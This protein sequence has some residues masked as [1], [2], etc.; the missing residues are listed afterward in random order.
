M[1]TH[2]DGAADTA[3]A[4]ADHIDF[5]NRHASEFAPSPSEVDGRLALIKEKHARMQ[6]TGDWHANLHDFPKDPGMFARRAPQNITGEDADLLEE[7]LPGPSTGT[8]LA[9]DRVD[10]STGTRTRGRAMNAE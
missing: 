4:L 2:D 9:L 3:A 5:V 10:V 7:S 8:S 6:F 1:T